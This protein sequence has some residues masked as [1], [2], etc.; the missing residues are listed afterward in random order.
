MPWVWVDKAFD[1]HRSCSRLLMTRTGSV[2]ERVIFGNVID[3]QED[4][5]SLLRLMDLVKPTM[6]V[7]TRISGG[8]GQRSA[9]CL[10]TRLCRMQCNGSGTGATAARLVLEGIP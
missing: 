6:Y 8:R 1:P 3:R 4:F 2:A 5:I 10:V 9:T 7:P